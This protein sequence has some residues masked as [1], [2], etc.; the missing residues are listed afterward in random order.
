MNTR[1]NGTATERHLPYQITLQLP[2]T[3]HR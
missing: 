2:I 3:L 1:L